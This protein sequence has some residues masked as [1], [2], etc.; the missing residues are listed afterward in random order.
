M[1]VNLLLKGKKMLDKFENVGNI[2]H[3]YSLYTEDGFSYYFTCFT[4]GKFEI[5]DEEQSPMLI[6]EWGG[7]GV[8]N[9]RIPE[10][11]DTNATLV[12]IGNLIFQM[13]E[14]IEQYEN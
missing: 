1:S 3:S 14:K 5:R 12:D 13:L 8:I 4:N 2:D 10:Q 6:G 7:T 11:Y 9:A